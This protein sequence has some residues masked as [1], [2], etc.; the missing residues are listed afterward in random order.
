MTY[1]RLFKNLITIIIIY[2]FINIPVVYSK[3]E[4]KKDEINSLIKDLETFAS[5]FN[6][7]KQV[8]VDEPSNEELFEHAIKGMITGLDPHSDYLKPKKQK[9][10]IENTTGKF[11]GLGI[12]IAKED[13]YILIISPIDDTPAYRAGIKSG[14]LIIKIDDKSTNG[15]AIE[16]AVSLM[17]GKPGTSV[18]LTI[19]RN[20]QKP[21]VVNIVREVIK[22]TSVKGYLLYE[23]IGYVRISSFQNPTANLLKQTIKKLNQ[24]NNGKLKSLIIDL[25]NNPGGLLQSA[26]DV[27]NLFIN[28]KGLIVYTKGRI[29]SS[30]VKF[31]TKPGDIMSSAPIVVLI[32]E[33]SASA[34]EIVAGALQDHKRAV[35]MGKTSFGKGSVQTILELKNGYGIK[36]TTSRYYTPLGRSIQAKGIEPDIILENITLNEEEEEGFITKEKNLDSHLKIEDPSTLSQEEILK[37]Q[38][39][40]KDE[41][42]K[43]TIEI[44][45]KDYFVH[46]AINVL[47]AFITVNK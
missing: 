18:N 16:D 43:K 4:N 42:T 39:D 33:G 37:S 36:I 8:Y 19:K 2:S 6:N 25:R 22:I 46:E 34:S 47:K 32:N 23:D 14:D 13:D 29:K 40:T 11:E 9:E 28:E 17:R 3:N 31:N 5:I 12:Y 38:E 1:F 15:M 24:E 27:A 21:F 10:L 26:V 35:I 30:N 45:K 7:I 41:N 44:L 20:N